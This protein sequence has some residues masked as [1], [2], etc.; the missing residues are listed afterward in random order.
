MPF[1]ESQ[2]VIPKTFY[3]VSFYCREAIAKSYF[4]ENWVS[5]IGLS[6]FS[7]YGPNEWH[8]KTY[9]NN[10]SQFLWDMEKG[11]S[12]EIYGDGTQTRDFTFVEDVVQ[13]N[14]LAM[15]SDNKLGLYN[16]GTGIE[17]SFNQVIQLLNKHL[18]SSIK[19]TYHTNPIKHYVYRTLADISRAAKELGYKPKWSIDEGIKSLITLEEKPHLVAK[20]NSQLA[21]A[22]FLT[23]S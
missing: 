13:A 18:K 23:F 8:K 9:A 6:Y 21:N 16:V 7:V 3:E 1:S 15:K 2:N 4:L 20:A 14:I 5:S 22:L 17:T 10:I 12:P 11:K 19:S